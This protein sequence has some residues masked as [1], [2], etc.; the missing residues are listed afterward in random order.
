MVVT[1]R[2]L[3]LLI[4][5]AIPFAA[6]LNAQAQD[7]Y[8]LAHDVILKSAG[9]YYWSQ[10]RAA[11]IPGAKP[12]VLL[13]TQEMEKAGTHGYRD[14]FTTSTIDNGK[15][16]G[17]PDRVDTLR[18]VRM[19]EGHDFVIGD[20]CP[21]WHAAT[22]KVLATG[23]TFG[24]RGGVKEDRLLERVSYS[25]YVPETKVWS[26][27]KLLPLPEKDHEGRVIEAPNAGC[28]QRYD[29]PTGEILLPIR[30]QKDAKKRQ[31][32]TIVAKCGFD[33]ET[34]TYKEHG[35]ELTIPRERGF[36]EP[37]VTGYGGRF[38]LTLR[39]DHSAFVA[40]SKDGLNYQEPIEWRYDDGAVLGSYNTQQH[41]VAHSS[42]LYLVYT[43]KGAGNDHVFRHRAPLFIAQVD[44]EKLCVLR[45]TECVLMP[46]TGL[47]LGAGFG[48]LD[49]RAK[50]TWVVSSEMSFP[51]ERQN[52]PNRVLLTRI[53]WTEPNLL[54]TAAAGSP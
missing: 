6:N 9:P 7:A 19:E 49:V 13:V 40:R 51:K 38:F 27:L 48:V 28:N 18:R 26:G 36:Y 1:N 8:R 44:P 23:K 20:V 14:V 29:L 53:L 12:Q 17:T 54:F 31:Y 47:D 25:V 5:L 15:T 11:F 33:G 52:E 42:G 41:W 37:S 46:E 50:E 4:L 39:A 30:Y 35:S 2:C 21:Q 22:K 45:K 16:W 43:R 10:S 3:L 32:T 24:F 34:L